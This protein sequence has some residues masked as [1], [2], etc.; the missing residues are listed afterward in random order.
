MYNFRRICNNRCEKIFSVLHNDSQKIAGLNFLDRV[1]EYDPP[2]PHQRTVQLRGDFQCLFCFTGIAEPAKLQPFVKE[3]DSILFL[4]KP[5]DAVTV[6]SAKQAEDILFIW[7][8]LEVK[9]HNGCQSINPGPQIRIACGNI[10]FLK[11]GCVI[12]HGEFLLSG[13]VILLRPNL[14]FRGRGFLSG[15]PDPDGKRMMYLVMQLEI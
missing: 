3:K 1:S 8:K 2:S 9:F 15:L 10:N 11:A 6:P 5:F 7:I 14:R 12:Q 13:R 4:Y